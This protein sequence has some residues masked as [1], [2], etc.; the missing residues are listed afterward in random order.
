MH[1][2][3]K[4]VWH[5]ESCSTLTENFPSSF[6][7]TTWSTYQK[8]L[9]Q[10]QAS[11]SSAISTEILRVSHTLRNAFTNEEAVSAKTLLTRISSLQEGFDIIS[12]LNRRRKRADSLNSAWNDLQWVGDANK[13]G[14]E[15]TE[16]VTLE[17]NLL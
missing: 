13:W 17:V 9:Y 11:L 8:E 10:V 14:K 15:Q 7:A 3:F 4:E 12:F 6:E 16:S 5:R 2:H 1:T